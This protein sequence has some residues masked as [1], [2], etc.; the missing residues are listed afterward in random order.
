M[1]EVEREKEIWR[2]T[3]IKNKLD[4]GN[5][6]ERRKQNIVKWETNKINK[7]KRKQ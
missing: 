5:K 4:T 7:T 1:T 2:T 3:K 6:Y